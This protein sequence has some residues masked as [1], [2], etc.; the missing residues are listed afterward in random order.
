[1]WE[2]CTG[3][4]QAEC[5]GDAWHSQG[6][7]GA[8]E[9]RE[10]EAIARAVAE[11]TPLCSC[12]ITVEI[13]RLSS[14]DRRQSADREYCVDNQVHSLPEDGVD[15]SRNELMPVLEGYGGRINCPLPT[16]YLTQPHL[17]GSMRGPPAIITHESCTVQRWVLYQRSQPTNSMH[18]Q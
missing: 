3:D 10:R 15:Q 14:A 4:A 5:G 2:C 17:P 9:I 7:I 18:Y 16:L 12:Q 8:G 11:F 1:M 6:K 13:R